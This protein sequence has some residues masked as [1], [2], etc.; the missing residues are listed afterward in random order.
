MLCDQWNTAERY[1]VDLKSRTKAPLRTADTRSRFSRW[2]QITITQF[3]FFTNT[4]L[5]LTTASIGFA[6]GQASML[7]GC[8]SYVLLLGIFILGVS[9]F[10][11]LL[12]SW[13]RLLDFRLTAQ[14]ANASGQCELDDIRDNA[15]ATADRLGDLS[16]CLL[17]CQL[18]TFGLGVFVVVAVALF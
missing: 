13:N 5:V 6:V 2:Q 1:V 14:I 9:G 4:V 12:C 16:W 18:L 15:K 7:P 17:K 11:A 3:G 10:L 8:L